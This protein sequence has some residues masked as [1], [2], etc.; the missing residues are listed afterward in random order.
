MHGPSSAHPALL[1]I[2]LPDGTAHS[3]R[4]M[5][6]YQEFIVSGPSGEQHG[7]KKIGF[8]QAC[9]TAWPHIDTSGRSTD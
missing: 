7:H 8:W 1:A 6:L 5:S 4:L 9:M 3:A 2:P